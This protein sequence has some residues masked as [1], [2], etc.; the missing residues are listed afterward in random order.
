VKRPD[1]GRQEQCAH[2][3]ENRDAQLAGLAA[4]RRPGKLSR[5]LN[6]QKNLPG[7]FQERFTGWSQSQPLFVSVEQLRPDFILQVVNLAAERRLRDVQAFCGLA[8]IQSVG[9]FHKI[10]KMGFFLAFF[11]AISRSRSFWVIRS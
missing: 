8:D 1:D 9:G 6:L 7:L 10:S 3:R 2:R 4:A 11:S 5:A